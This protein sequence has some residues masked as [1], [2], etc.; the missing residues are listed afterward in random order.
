MK[1]CELG[2]ILKMRMSDNAFGKVVGFQ[3]PM[4][5][6]DGTMVVH[7]GSNPLISK[8]GKFGIRLGQKCDQTPLNDIQSPTLVK[9]FNAHDLLTFSIFHMYNIFFIHV[10]LIMFQIVYQTICINIIC[11]LVSMY[12]V[13][14]FIYQ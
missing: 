3:I 11:F 5:L 9:E 14:H 12:F 10:V 2:W 8:H 6:D 1:K 13:L 4:P 7:T